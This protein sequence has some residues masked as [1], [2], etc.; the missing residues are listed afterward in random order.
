MLRGLLDRLVLI[1][2]VIIGGCI[3]GFIQQYRQRV[4]GRLDQVQLDLAP[5]Q[6]IAR[7]FHDGDMD[8][9]VGHHLASTDATFHAEGEALRAMLE[10]LARLQAVVEGL[11]GSV[12]QQVGFLLR[13]YDQD[14]GAATWRD[15]VPNFSLDAGSIVIALTVGVIFWLVF[16]LVWVLARW[17]K[18]E[19]AARLA[20]RPPFIP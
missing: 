8:K 11:A 1:A 13:H 17:L 7:R 15:H 19:V 18:E 12:W 4:G 14:I 5:F 2:G 16:Q 9:M 6:E 10:S 20:P 3:P